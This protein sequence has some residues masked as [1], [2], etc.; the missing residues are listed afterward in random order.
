MSERPRLD[1]RRQ[2][3][4][5]HVLV[6]TDAPSLT[7][8]LNEGLPLGGFWVSTIASGLQTL[9]VFRLRQFDL[10]LIDRDLESFDADELIRRLRGTSTNASQTPRTLAPIV[11]IGEHAATSTPDEAATLGIAASLTAPIEL[12]DVVQTLHAVFAQWRQ[13]NPDAPLADAASA[14]A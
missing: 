9:E 11:T 14:T 6:V 8:F 10:L 4:R 5:P 3:E 2:H 12:E 13:D 7:E 1:A